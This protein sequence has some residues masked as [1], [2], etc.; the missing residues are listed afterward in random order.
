ML[1]EVGES[2]GGHPDAGPPPTRKHENVVSVSSRSTAAHLAVESMIER[3]CTEK[4]HRARQRGRGVRCDELPR[5][6]V[7][8][9]VPISCAARTPFSPSNIFVCAVA[10]GI[11]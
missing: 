6:V 10:G 11:M 8:A 2:R 3:R 7:V 9:G 1:K 4:V 5:L